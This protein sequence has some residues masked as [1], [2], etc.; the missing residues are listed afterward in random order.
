MRRMRRTAS[1]VFGLSLAELSLILVFLLLSLLA[2]TAPADD[3]KKEDVDDLKAQLA[4]FE[5]FKRQ[6]DDLFAKLGITMESLQTL[7][8]RLISAN[9]VEKDKRD[10]VRLIEDLLA[11]NQ[12]LREQVVALGKAV[13]DLEQEVD[14]LQDDGGTEPGSC[15]ISEDGKTE[16]FLRVR[17]F[18]DR[19]RFLPAWPARRVEDMSAFGIS[20][21]LP[22]GNLSNDAFATFSY[23]IYLETQSHGCR[24]FVIL[25]DDTTG[26]ASYKK[27]KDL[28]ERYFF[29]FEPR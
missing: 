4:E 9:L 7:A 10:L 17:M 22:Q 27:Q 11:E 21:E 5:R 23:P 12:E 2:I 8:S 3:F 6:V 25:Q 19:F 13:E 16:Y 28:V 26:K 24:L 15:W 14:E 1:R 20:L 29:V 18:D